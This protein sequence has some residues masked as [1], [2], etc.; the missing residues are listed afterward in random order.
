MRSV[1]VRDLKNKLSEYLRLVSAG[2]PVLVTDHGR[3]IAQ[4]SAPPAYARCLEESERQALE[5]LSHA[6]TLRLGYGELCSATEAQPAALAVDPDELE[7]A[8]AAVRADRA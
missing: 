2:E 6:G 8:L 4:L 3:V 1:G 7:Q 5:R